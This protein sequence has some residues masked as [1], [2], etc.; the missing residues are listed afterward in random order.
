MEDFMKGKFIS[1]EGPDGAGKSTVMKKVLEQ[2]EPEL[3]P[4]YLV[5]R[6]P[7]GSKIA[8]KI[9][10]LI[11]DPENDQMSARTEALLYA[12]SRSQLIQEVIK[13]A[14]N[15]GILVFSD[16]FV[17]SSL[18]YQGAGREL[19]ISEVAAINRF[20]TEGISPDLTLF[21]DIAPE[22]G[23]ARIKKVRPDDEDR[24]EREKLAFH[25]RVYAGYQ[26]I[27][28]RYPERIVVI[29]ADRPV[30]EVTEEAIATIKNRL[31][32]IF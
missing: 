32:E 8:E 20:A 11:L 6:E 26:E 23:L 1:F 13:P 17:D 27:I 9:R 2:L 15:S 28:K 4:Q 31:P 12:S 25:Q 24:L 5:T 18:A 14:L 21:F 7:G 10:K 16:R 30:E 19:G 22:K 29:K 3:K